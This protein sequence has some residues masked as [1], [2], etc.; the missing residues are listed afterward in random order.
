MRF[1]FV[2]VLLVGIYPLLSTMR[3]FCESEYGSSFMRCVTQHYIT[4]HWGGGGYEIIFLNNV[5]VLQHN[6]QF[7]FTYYSLFS[8]AL[9]SCTVLLFVYILVT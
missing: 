8:C 5:T 2:F 9:L 1:C 6:V 7:I 3:L 4:L